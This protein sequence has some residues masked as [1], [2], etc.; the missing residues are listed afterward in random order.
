MMRTHTCGEL[1]ADDL[2][3]QVQLA[4]WVRF[5]RDHGGVLFF[6]LADAY[7]ITQ[8]V[9]DP[10]AMK[11]T[12]VKGMECLLKTFGRESVISVNGVVRNRVPGTEDTRNPTGQIELLIESAKLLNS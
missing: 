10:E 11:N 12:D 7:G 6:D 9:F 1:R 4:G 2:G 8:T 5:S 3:Q